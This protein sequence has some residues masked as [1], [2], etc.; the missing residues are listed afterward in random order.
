MSSTAAAMQAISTGSQIAVEAYTIPERMVRA[1]EAAAARG[2]HVSV[3]LQESPF[4]SSGAHLARV[5]RRIAA[6]LR[7]HHVSTK[8]RDEVHAKAIAVD[9]AWYF[10]EKNWR[11][12][13][14][15][16][17]AS[18]AEAAS[19]PMT[20]AQAL[21]REAQLLRRATARDAPIVESESFGSGNCVYDAL[22][23]RAL[24]GAAPR[25]LVGSRILHGN[26]RERKVLEALMRDGARVRVCKDSSKFAACGD[27]VWLG[28]ANASVTVAG[29]RM[30][31]WGAYTSN[32]RI[33]AAVRQRL[34]TQWK[35]AREL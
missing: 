10:D 8:L 30:S 15:V 26:G 6:Q 1:L 9:G 18:G 35:S 34:E 20:K 33:V 24:A 27:R 29:D 12:G 23:A 25:V 32:R 17:R 14:L 22:K 16:V 21:R 31:D 13:D 28:S 2:A 19:I 5:N 3:R 4:G 11:G 7:A